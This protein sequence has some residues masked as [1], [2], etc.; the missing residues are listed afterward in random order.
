M[1][2]HMGKATAANI[3][4]LTNPDVSKFCPKPGCF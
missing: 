4:A 1:S 2:Q 3:F